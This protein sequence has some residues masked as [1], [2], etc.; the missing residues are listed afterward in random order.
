MIVSERVIKRDSYIFFIVVMSAF[1]EFI[2]KAGVAVAK[3]TAWIADLFLK[4]G[5]WIYK[6]FEA[7]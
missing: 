7:I 4:M 1:T 6:Q 3:A 2:V 5:Q